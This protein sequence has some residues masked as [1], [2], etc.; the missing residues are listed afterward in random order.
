[1]IWSSRRSVRGLP[2]PR[3]RVATLTQR[4]VLRSKQPSRLP[5]LSVF[6]QSV[7]SIPPAAR[8]H[9]SSRHFGDF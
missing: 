8:V 5:M 6:R 7:S 4:K 1:M 2:T 9:S 3:R